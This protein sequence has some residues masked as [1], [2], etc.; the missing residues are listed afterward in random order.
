MMMVIFHD[1]DSD[2]EEA[3]VTCNLEV[4]LVLG[5]VMAVFISPQVFLKSRAHPRG[6]LTE[7]EETVDGYT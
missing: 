6:R 3:G 1:D 7:G 4:A 2:I 5:R